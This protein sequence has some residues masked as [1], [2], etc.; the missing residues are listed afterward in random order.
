MQYSLR[1]NQNVWSFLSLTHHLAKF[2]ENLSDSFYVFLHTAMKTSLAEV[3]NR[4]SLNHM[5]LS[6]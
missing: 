4:K 6:S 5:E 2:H 1:N 3:I